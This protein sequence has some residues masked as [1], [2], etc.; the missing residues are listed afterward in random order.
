MR[1]TNMPIVNVGLGFTIFTQVGHDL[2]VHV[3]K[4]WFFHLGMCH[5]IR[6]HHHPN[7]AWLSFGVFWIEFNPKPPTL[8]V[9]V[10]HQQWGY[11]HVG[12]FFF[13]RVLFT[14]SLLPFFCSNFF[15]IFGKWL[16]W[17][18]FI[19]IASLWLQ[20]LYF[21]RYYLPLKCVCFMQ[22]MPL[23]S[24]ASS[25]LMAS[26]FSRTFCFQFGFCSSCRNNLSFK[27]WKVGCATKLVGNFRVYTSG[28][29]LCKI[30]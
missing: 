6:T 12:V 7:L 23:I 11:L 27:T 29:G 3:H 5:F 20:P 22:N 1:V 16:K 10:F 25:C 15:T 9:D 30:S 24:A 17:T 18:C 4:I 13:F 19:Y 2:Q 26:T 21:T 14:P 28:C 8:E